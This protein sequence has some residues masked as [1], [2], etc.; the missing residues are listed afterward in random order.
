MLEDMVKPNSVY[1]VSSKV[2]VDLMTV[3]FTTRYVKRPMHLF[4]L[5]GTMSFA[6]G[7]LVNLYLTYEW[8]LG[9]PLKTDHYYSSVYY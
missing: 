3:V 9:I 4:G 1:H 5:V 7:V 6:L 8:F 2:F